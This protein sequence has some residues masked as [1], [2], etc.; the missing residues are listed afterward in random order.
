MTMNPIPQLAEALQR[1]SLALFYGA[2]LPR[3]LTGR[4]G[5]AALAAALAQRLG[6]S[7]PPPAW[8][9]VA[10][11]YEADAGRNALIRWLRDQLDAGG[12]RP[13]PIYDLLAQLP[14][15]TYITTAYDPWL[16]D[17][18]RDAGRRP[19]LPVVDAASLGLRDPGR[20]TVVHLL[21]VYDRP[22]SLALTAAD[23]RQ[24]AESRRQ[25]L[26]G[27]VHP[28]LANQSVLILGQDLRDA[29]F[30]TLY[31]NALFQA[32]TIRP[33]AYAIWPGLADWEVQ[34]WAR[35]EVRVVDRPALDLLRELLGSGQAGP[36]VG[37]PAPAAEQQAARPGTMQFARLHVDPD[38]LDRF[39]LSGLLRELL[40][41]A[42]TTTEALKRF[43]QDRADFRAI[44]P[45]FG[46]G[47]GLD[48]MV[49]RVIEHCETFV[50]LDEL[51]IAI[52]QANPRQYAR[53]EPRL[54]SH[55]AIQVLDGK[56]IVVDVTP[57]EG[58]KAPAA[59][60]NGTP[61]PVRTEPQPPRFYDF[62]LLVGDPLD[63]SYPVH[64]L[65]SPAGQAEGTFVPP[66]A[67]AEL[68]DALARLERGA[69]DEAFLVDLGTRL[70]RALFDGDVRARYAESAGIVAAGIIAAG[71]IAATAAGAGLRLRLR[72]DPPELN[73]LP[74]E[75]L[76]DPEKREFLVLS[77]RALVTRY[78]PVPRPTPPLA[79]EPP[80]RVLVVLAAP[81]DQP[82]LDVEAE[83]EH[84]GQALRP[85]IDGGQVT[86]AVEQHVTKRGLRQQ[87][88]Q[89]NPHVL[90]YVG[91]GG[92][93]RDRGRGVLLLENGQALTDPLDSSMLGTLLKG[94][95]VR[96]AVLN[97][98][99]SAREAPAAGP[100]FARR[101]AAFLGVG[102]A[103]VDAGLGAVVAMQFTLADASAR[104]F[105][106]DFYDMLAR[107]LPVD[108]CV[109]RAR[110]ALLL[111][112]GPDRADWATPVLF[113]RAPDG[114][115]FRTCNAP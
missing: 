71:M 48:D 94:S 38:Q 98:C 23:L 57:P 91:H 58:A 72:L 62:E 41:A 34:T 78:L 45:K 20:P 105:A 52:A 95:A 12:R 40:T 65:A 64:V 33:P 90:H 4:P 92:L 115:L 2:D 21:G 7:G 80:L 79:V 68:A 31:Q 43:C 35:Q 50:L 30:A 67:E 49:D 16:H 32:G 110:E 54:K 89:V 84:I 19:N 55:G 56:F 25:I 108:E 11:Q 96:L 42:F 61:V 86:L 59:V 3:E 93:D 102:P 106:E 51:L 14:V 88:M 107:S 101:R 39:P 53:F 47:H 26:A 37:S 18:L 70:F 81:R 66:L 8:P 28:A 29:H 99:L 5:R 24:L 103:L 77:K 10:A 13:G 85:L 111:E 114:M 27:L 75:L 109:S 36:A 15:L 97:A 22:E 83:A 113:M 82:V 74:W 63:G 76:R 44:L 104:L 60:A 100:S 87:L 46:S 6:L 1:G 69:S 112:V 9:D 73:A 17:A